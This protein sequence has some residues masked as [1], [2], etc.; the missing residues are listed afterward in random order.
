M[1]C[2]FN[3]GFHIEVHFGFPL[4]EFTYTILPLHQS[5]TKQGTLII[6]TELINFILAYQTNISGV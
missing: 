6:F 1:F 5:H 2:Y 4:V 3:V